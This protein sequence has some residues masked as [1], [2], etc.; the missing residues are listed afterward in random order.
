MKL[1]AVEPKDNYIVRVYLDNNAM[2]DFDVKAELE[3][4]PC[5]KPLYDPALFKQVAFKNKRI[6]W[7]EQCDFHLDQILE[8]GRFVHSDAAPK[9][10]DT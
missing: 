4:I 7:N 10:S 2:I 6:F 1:I 5:Y 9:A 8:R 3:R